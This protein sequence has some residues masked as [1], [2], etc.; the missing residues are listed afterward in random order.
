MRARNPFRRWSVALVVAAVPILL[1][2]PSTTVLA[3]QSPTPAAQ[4]L[5][6]LGS[7]ELTANRAFAQPSPHSA[8]LRSVSFAVSPALTL[9]SSSVSPAVAAVSAGRQH[10]MLNSGLGRPRSGLSAG[11]PP[12]NLIGYD[13]IQQGDAISK[14]GQLDENLA[15][16]DPD[17]AV[18]PSQ[19]VEVTSSAMYVFPPNEGL[20]FTLDLNAFVN[21]PLYAGYAVTDAHIVYNS[22]SRRFFLSELDTDKRDISVCGDDPSSEFVL[23]SPSSTLSVNDVWAGFVW[24]PG[25]SVADGLTG[26]QPALG[27]STNLVTSTQNAFDTCNGSFNESEMLVVQKSDLLNG[28]FNPNT[29]AVDVENGPLSPQPVVELAANQYQYV[30]WNNSDSAEGGC[31]PSCSVGVTTVG[32]TPEAHNVVIYA[33]VYEPMTPTVVQCSTT[34]ANP[35][36]DQLGTTS[37]LQTGDDRFLSAVWYGNTIWTAGN[38][39]CTPSGDTAPR[40]CLD[41]VS[42]SAD[43]SG[44]VTAGSQINDVGVSGAFLFFPAVTI[45][46]SGNMITV[47]DESSPTTYKSIQVAA[48]DAGSATLSSFTT[49]HASGNYYASWCGQTGLLPCS[50]GAYSGAAVDPNDPRDVW[51]VSEDNDGNVQPICTNDP[52]VCWDTWIARYTF[53][54][55]S[56]SSLSPS[57]G[58]VAGGQTVTVAGSEIAAGATVTFDGSP[59][60]VFPRT[61]DSFAFVTPQHATTGGTVQLQVADSV[62][63]SIEDAATAYT[64]VGLANFVPVTPFRILDTRSPGSG[65][66]LGPGVI[67][68]LQVTDIGTS[69]IPPSATAAVLNVT[70]VNGTSASLFTVYAFGASRPNASNLNF[71]PHTAIA[72]L[73]TVA[74]GPGGKVNI[75]NALGSVNVVVDVEGYFTPK[76]VSDVQGLFHPINPVRV[77]D[78]RHNSPTPACS[79]RGALGPQASRV[80]VVSGAGGIP[81]DG[82][83]DAAVVNLTGVAGTAATYL[84]LFPSNASGGCAYGGSKSPPSSMVNLTTDAVRANRVMVALGPSKLGG[85]DD[86]VCVYNAAGTINFLIDANGWYGSATAPTT[87][88]GYQ[89]QA[90]V[91]TRICDTR[92]SSEYCS[93]GAIGKASILRIDVVGIQGIPATGSGTTVVAIIA[94]LTAV[95]PTSAT[96]LT[97]YPGDLS[98]TPSVSDV[99]VNAGAVVPNLDVVKLAGTPNV[100]TGTVDLY[101][102]AGSVNAIVDVEGW[103]Q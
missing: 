6:N 38:T 41:F 61:P 49:V 93:Q 86:A 2:M 16:A 36:A 24:V 22:Q 17:I 42:V 27:I 66:A 65:G 80:V 39:T 45:N 76:P 13:G 71:A 102:G 47:F 30:V 72:N 51:V 88:S 96:Y 83:A 79:A 19:V 9:R 25:K 55:P 10:A 81:G 46:S 82:T 91:P 14:L 74:L 89:Y 67:R 103:F 92:S 44:D 1:A 33:P 57:S 68:A 100:A 8:R 77:C 63:A 95:A 52:H 11:I 85:P 4:R 48:V 34:C 28:L 84:T 64:Y 90:F 87:P 53:A 50:W 7:D 26:R 101:N 60:A 69:P 75:Y 5:G 98:R 21:G 56:I 43:V 40:S 29:S 35:P 3:A 23:V 78:T 94:N 20:E 59:I 18:G 97:L 58:P 31:T 99:S 54:A 62:G 70:E 12:V 37:Q 73:V 32:G 15:P